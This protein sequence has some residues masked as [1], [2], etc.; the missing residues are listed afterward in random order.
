MKKFFTTLVVTLA[1]STLL[2]LLY[3]TI[4][5]GLPKI[6]YSKLQFT[7]IPG[8]IFILIAFQRFTGN[9]IVRNGGNDIY[10]SS[11]SNQFDQQERINKAKSLD[12]D[13]ISTLSF[14]TSGIILVAFAF[15]IV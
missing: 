3:C 6:F 9:P 12:P 4:D 14:L 2:T 10:V 15:I 13:T 7:M 8:I 11:N 5:L 1:I